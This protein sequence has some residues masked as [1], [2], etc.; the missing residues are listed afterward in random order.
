MS[1]SEAESVDVSIWQ[2]CPLD[3][4]NRA[5]LCPLAS[6]VPQIK[7][8]KNVQLHTKRST[9][10]ESIV[11]IIDWLLKH[12]LQANDIW[13]GIS[14]GTMI[15]A[16]SAPPRGL[17]A[18]QLV[19]NLPTTFGK[20]DVGIVAGVYTSMKDG[21]T[22]DLLDK[23]H[24]KD[25][26]AIKDAFRMQAR[27]GAVSWCAV[28]G[29][30]VDSVFP[31]PRNQ[32]TG[33]LAIRS[34][35]VFKGILLQGTV[36]LPE[37]GHFREHAYR[38]FSLLLGAALEWPPS[39]CSDRFGGS[40]SS[41]SAFRSKIAPLWACS[42]RQRQCLNDVPRSRVTRFFGMHAFLGAQRV[43]R[44]GAD[45]DSRAVDSWEKW[46]C[47]RTTTFVHLPSTRPNFLASG[48][49]SSSR[50]SV[51]AYISACAWMCLRMPEQAGCCL[52]QHEG[53]CAPL[54]VYEC[55]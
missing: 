48:I 19:A 29:G 8:H 54:Q 37:T 23:M 51:A 50:P 27:S 34:V 40:T 47:T 15:Q 46:T 42:P 33:P 30:A 6:R 1:P 49:P 12:P 24:D 38:D 39:L 16:A 22:A 10:R 11:R 9:A 14:N 45:G 31:C 21:P 53:V 32:E 55:V 4:G 17:S 52:I 7:P 18:G 13:C 35:H 5:A 41:R 28:G 26:Q 2:R 20:L 36:S 43:Y 3:R 25:A 44:R